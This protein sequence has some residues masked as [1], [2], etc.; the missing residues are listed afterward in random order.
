MSDSTRPT[1]EQQHASDIKTLQKVYDQLAEQRRQLQLD[2]QAAGRQFGST[3]LREFEARQQR[4]HEVTEQMR[5]LSRDMRDL[6]QLLWK[7]RGPSIEEQLGQYAEPEE[8]PR[9]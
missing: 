9:R 2:M 4:C 1:P 8:G 3:E 6:R 7:G 5:Q